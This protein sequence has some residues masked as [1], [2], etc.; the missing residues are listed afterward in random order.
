MA[1]GLADR[2]TDDELIDLVLAQARFPQRA[3]IRIS[4][5]PG[6]V[7]DLVHECAHGLGEAFVIE[8]CAADLRRRLALPFEDSRN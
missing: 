7:R 2:G 5:H 3:D 4:D 6:A 1:S 8:G